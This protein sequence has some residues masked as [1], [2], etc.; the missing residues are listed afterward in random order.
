MSNDVINIDGIKTKIYFV[1]KGII[2]PLFGL[3]T[4]DNTS[5]GLMGTIKIQKN[6]PDKVSKFIKEHEIFHI[7]DYK[8][9][10]GWFMREIRANIFALIKEPIGFLETTIL[11][12]TNPDRRI[13]YFKKLLNMN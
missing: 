1:E 2:Q 5:K 13:Y 4:V 12:I 6:L 3:A 10:G 7:K 8:H 11:T 9:Q